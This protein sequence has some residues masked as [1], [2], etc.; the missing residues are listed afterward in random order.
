M[1]NKI[2]TAK[3]SQDDWLECRRKTIGGSDAAALC[4]LNSYSSPYSVWADKMGI[5][6]TKEPN[7]AMRLGTDL[8]QYVA[9]RFTEATGKKVRR[10]RHIIINSDYPFAHANVDR[11]VIGEDAGLECKTTSIMNLK[12][13]KNG[14]FPDNYYVQ[15]MHYMMVTGKK[16]WYLAVLILGKDFRVFEIE[17]N[18]EEINALIDIEKNFYEHMQNKTAPAIDG[19]TATTEALNSIYSEDN[20]E[21][22]DLTFY[23]SE[24]QQFLDAEAQIKVLNEFCDSKANIIKEVMKNCESGFCG[25]FN[26][27]WKSQQRR[28]LD[29]KRLLSDNPSLDLSKYEKTSNFRTFKIS[30]KGV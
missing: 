15:C 29:K 12:K 24:I 3:M 22:A 30:E 10:D 19:F 8:E 5:L 7:E 14:E 4:G 21:Q 28:T 27:M 9:E 25:N 2:S 20:G 11:V 26:V 23:K 17:R 1:I 18:N 16:K 6:P 13:F